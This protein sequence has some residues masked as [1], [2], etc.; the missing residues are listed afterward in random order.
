M[1]AVGAILFATG[2][3]IGGWQ[4]KATQTTLSQQTPTNQSSDDLFEDGSALPSIVRGIIV[5]ITTDQLIVQTDATPTAPAGR[6]AVATTIQT[7]FLESTS[8]D[9]DTLAREQNTYNQELAKNPLT[10]HSPPAPFIEATINRSALSVGDAIEV[11]SDSDPS[12]E[13]LHAL[14]ITRINQAP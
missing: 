10:E 11:L 2:Y 5:E 14:F 1:I 4:M 9:A 12:S 13:V 3:L 8:K 6:V 7:E